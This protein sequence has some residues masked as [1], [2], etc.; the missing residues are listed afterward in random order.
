MQRA[1]TTFSL[2]FLFGVAACAS[3]RGVPEIPYVDEEGT[4]GITGGAGPFAL[5]GTLN[6]DDDT[7]HL[8][9]RDG[10]CRGPMVITGN[11]RTQLLRIGCQAAIVEFKMSNGKI[12]GSGKAS[13]VIQEN[14]PGRR[15]CAMWS[16]DPKTGVRT[17]ERW[18]EEPERRPVRYSGSVSAV[19]VS[20]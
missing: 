15:V 6:F 7:F 3:S 5:S 11:S 19:S 9:W 20:G 8:I 12:T 17:C 14:R 1:V 13:V 4:F 18:D 10:D 16:R 2:L